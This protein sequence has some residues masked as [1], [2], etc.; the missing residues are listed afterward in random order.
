LRFITRHPLVILFI[1]G[2]LALSY[3][4]YTKL[5]PSGAPGISGAPG[6]GGPPGRGPGGLGATT[7]TVALVGTQI[8]VDRVESVGTAQASESVTITPKVSDIVTRI[9]FSDGDIV[10]RGDLL[11]ELT[12]TAET[13]RLAE[14]QTALDDARRQLARIQ[15]L[16]NDNL[17]SRADL[18]DALSRVDTARARFEGVVANMSDR[19]IV[20]PF[21]G[22]LGFR[23]I[24][25][26][27]FVTPNTVITTL[28]DISTI[29]LDFTVAESYLAQLGSGLEIQANSIV[30]PGRPF[31][32]SVQVIGSRVDA[33]TRSVLVR[34]NIAN[35]DAA[36]R[37]GM[38]MTVGMMLNER[39]A[40]VIPEQAVVPAQ[41]RQFVFV[42]DEENIARRIEVML[43]MRRP[44]IVEIVSGVVPG[45]RV[46]AEGVAQ[47][48]P[49]QPVRI[50]N[51]RQAGGATSAGESTSINTE[52]RRARS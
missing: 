44:G 5:Q 18:D 12:N 11:V 29:K 24:S 26:G 19:V 20:A 28:D 25:E 4:V 33:V 30:Y 35:P 3:G 32:G 37:P 36:L 31:V 13:A 1:A 22:M 43:G 51:T 39:E 41:G 27:S 52:Q 21:S 6:M 40:V 38:L 2:A 14:A 42:V 9:H 23:N 8:L 16:S 50:I 47:V 15:Q 10:E 49:N 7:V 48:R 46:I 34:A 45:Q 17:V